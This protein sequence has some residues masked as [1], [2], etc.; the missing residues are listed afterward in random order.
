[1]I[2]A[3]FN[4]LVVPDMPL[5]PGWV[6]KTHKLDC[7]LDKNA[8]LGQQLLVLIGK[9]QFHT[10]DYLDTLLLVERVT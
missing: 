8:Q 6:L 4:F 5:M 9:S 2:T 7:T 3:P 1:M 10:L